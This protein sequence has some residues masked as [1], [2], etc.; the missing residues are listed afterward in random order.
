MSL[1][2]PIA[3]QQRVPPA[4]DEGAGTGFDRLAAVRSSIPAVTHVD[5]SARVQTV[6]PQ[7]NPR[8]F[9]LL[10]EFHRQTGCPVL[11]NT[12][13]NVRG[14]PIVCS[15]RDAYDCF[16]RTGMDVLVLGTCVL[17]RTEQRGLRLGASTRL[18]ADWSTSG[19]SASTAG[20]RL[21]D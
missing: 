14:E 4:R 18:G 12:S 19:T 1:V 3:A 6:T 13:F 9:G 16:L 11:V 10:T 2:A 21:D 17:D 7:S 20:Y 15:P 5:H 8:F